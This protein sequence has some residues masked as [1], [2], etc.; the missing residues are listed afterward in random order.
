MGRAVDLELRSTWR[1]RL[2]R[3]STSGLSVAEYCRR[4]GTSVGTYYYWKRRLAAESNGR[5]ARAHNGASSSAGQ[6]SKPGGRIA[7]CTE[8]LPRAAFA[9]RVDAGGS[10]LPLPLT[11]PRGGA[12]VELTLMDGTVLRVP[13][14]NLA[15]LELVLT[16]LGGRRA[17][18]ADEETRHA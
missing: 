13:Q 5:A 9:T 7:A 15:A 12:W 8:G 3:Q 6:R 2:L 18:R 10:F 17:A 16:T 4:E 11:P 14:H 1:G